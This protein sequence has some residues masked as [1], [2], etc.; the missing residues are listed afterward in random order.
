LPSVQVEPPVQLSLTLPRVNTRTTRPTRTAMDL[1]SRE[2]MPSRKI[3]TKA[4]GATPEIQAFPP[5]GNWV[6]IPP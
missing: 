6:Y 1:R 2:I 3:S 4:P 5:G